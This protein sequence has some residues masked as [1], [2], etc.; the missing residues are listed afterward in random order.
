[1]TN[2]SRDLSGSDNISRPSVLVCINCLYHQKSGPGKTSV[3]IVFDA[4]EDCKF[5]EKVQEIHFD[6]RSNTSRYK[7]TCMI[8]RKVLHHDLVQIGC[9]HHILDNVRE[10]FDKGMYG[11]Y[12]P[13]NA[14]FN[15]FKGRL[16]WTSIAFKT[17]PVMN[18]QQVL[19]LISKHKRLKLM[20]LE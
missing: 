5:E 20:F 1:M 12:L 9:R 3:R 14:N 10:T 6:T 18:M 7:G 15:L 16:E 19:L 17:L 11:F 13:R 2:S 4:L 8:R